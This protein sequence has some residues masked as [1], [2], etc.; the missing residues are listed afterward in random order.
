MGA[1][2]GLVWRSRQ[3]NLSVHIGGDVRPGA[4]LLWFSRATES[5][6]LSKYDRF[7]ITETEGL[8]SDDA[9]TL[10]HAYW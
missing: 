7:A 10:K 5:F 9:C 1:D 2:V 3:P 4:G 6:N 8:W